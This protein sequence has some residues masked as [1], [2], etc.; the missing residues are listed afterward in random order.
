MATQSIWQ[1]DLSRD[2]VDVAVVG[3]GVVGASTAYAL[4]QLDAGLDV[5]LLDRSN[6]LA[7][8]ASGRN[9]GFLLPGTHPNVAATV[10]AFGESLAHRLWVFTRE[11]LEI[12]DH[13]CRQWDVGYNPTGSYIAA[14]SEDEAVG[15]KRSKKILEKWGEDFQLLEGARVEEEM[16]LVGF[17]VALRQP[18]GGMIHPVRLVNALVQQS[19][20]RV[21]LEHEIE[22]VEPILGHF[23]L[24]GD[25]GAIESERVVLATNAFASALVESLEGFVRPVRAQMLATEPAPLRLPAPVYSHEGYFYI[26]QRS[27][28]RYLVGG[29]R[30]LHEAE[31][32]GYEDVVTDALQADIEA[33]LGK[34]LS[35]DV[36]AVERR[37]S[38]VMGFS[39]DG[40]PVAGEVEQ[41]LVYGV[42]FTGHGMGYSL[43][44]GRLL[45][46][47]ALG[48]QDDAANLFSVERFTPA[49]QAR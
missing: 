42:G 14:G 32:V 20:C 23:V 22:T 34:H 18:I 13:E 15:L 6:S 46:R 21:L 47:L 40:L 41:G 17:A 37:W 43:R 44:F 7:A 10:D 12:I 45:A 8:E 9:A 31:E 49:T 16:G 29:A 25:W 2:R 11:N 1:A 35:G 4:S 28:G 48:F 33:Y 27:D 24:R 36:P 19:G 39:P 38:G 30:H 26:R 5:A 3:G